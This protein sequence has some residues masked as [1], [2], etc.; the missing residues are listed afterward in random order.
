MSTYTQ[1]LHHVV[2]REK[3]H[4]PFL[5][6]ENMEE[7]FR[8]IAG[9]LKNKNCHVYAVGGFKN[10]VHIIFSLH[11]VVALAYLVKDIKSGIHGMI[12]RNK[13][14]YRGFSGWQTGYSSF[15]YDPSAKDNLVKY[16]RNQERHHA[17]INFEEEL[18]R[19]LEEH[20]IPYEKKYLFK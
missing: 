2:F 13:S 15:T 5:T 16:V 17:N 4:V 14:K 7:I 8:Y 20:N 1:D 9:I 12:E 6:N 11:P 10:H 18:V 3:N 19:L